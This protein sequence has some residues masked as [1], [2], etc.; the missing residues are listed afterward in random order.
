MLSSDFIIHHALVSKEG[1][2]PSRWM[3]VL[4]GI[5]GSGGNF[6]SIARKLSESC[7]A[8]GFILV[9]L[10]GH[11][12]SQ[13]PPP[14]QTIDAAAED[15]IRLGRSLALPIAGV[16]GHS[17]G[18]KVAMAYLGR[19]P[20]ELDQAWVLDAGPGAHP[21]EA[22][23]SSTGAVLRMLEEMPTPLPSRERFLEIVLARGF[24]KSIADWL[25]MNL[26]RAEGGDGFRLRV[27]LQTIRALM[28]DYFAQDLWPVLEAPA[29][30]REVHIV[31]GGRSTAVSEADKERYRALAAR[32]PGALRVHDLP[33][34]GHWVHADDPEG[35]LALLRAALCA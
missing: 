20:G 1:A 19:R 12:L 7:P 4:H 2:P 32:S 33:S 16:M 30:A 10:R 27:D 29:V 3:L 17:F 21:E 23:E 13:S 6:R 25:A 22:Q 14:P 15:L 35:L 8:W 11:G 18:G 26:R 24:D 34:A 28:D 9:D 5:L 31:L